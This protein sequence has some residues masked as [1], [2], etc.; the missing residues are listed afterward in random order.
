MSIQPE[1][2][3]SDSPKD[4]VI[5]VAAG[6]GHRA[7]KGLP[8]QY[9]L[10]HGR[11]VIAHTIDAL[12]ECLPD[13]VIVPVIHADD[14]ELFNASGVE[15]RNIHEPVIGGST[16][17]AS[18]RNG[19]EALEGKSIKSVYIHDAARPFITSELFEAIS[20]AMDAGAKAVVPA[21]PV[22]D[23]L[24]RLNTDDM[25]ASSVDRS[26]IFAVQTPQVFPYDDILN[27]H[28]NADDDKY[29]DDASIFQ[30]NCSQVHYCP[31]TQQNFKI[32]TQAD[33]LRAEQMLRTQLTDVRTGTG[34]DVHRFDAGDHV[35]LCGVKV[36]FNFC[37]KGHSDAD[38]ALHALTDAVLASI[39]DGDIGFHF[40]P[41]DDAWRGVSSDRFLSFATE[42]VTAQGGQITNLSVTIICELPKI[43][44]H[45]QNMRQRIAEIAGIG[46]D[47]VSVQATTTE[48]LGFTGRGEGIAAQ[49]SATVRLP[50][51]K[52]I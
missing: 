41:S 4:A 11:S 50:E 15:V 47:R 38:V 45:M 16:R 36:P 24:V 1:N 14:F 17:Q 30:A 13:A 23:T 10:L 12:L 33:F 42:R 7:G 3:L 32:T 6:R 2:G 29:T 51:S 26:S 35:W 19:L 48:Q 21:L 39:A 8:K 27:A 31:G 40:P 5:L 28:R 49:A 52:N 22:V 25:Q 44:P 37:L 46:I 18:V 9:R 20:I 43:G 34:F